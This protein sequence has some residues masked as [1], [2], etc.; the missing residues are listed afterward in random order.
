MS[1]LLEK[2]SILLTP[3][4]YDDGKILSV[5][6][7]EV[8]GEEK[9]VNGTFDENVNGWITNNANASFVW[10]INKTALFTSTSFAY[11]KVSPT[12]NLNAAVYKVSFDILSFE[13]TLSNVHIGLGNSGNTITTTG[14]YTYFY[15]S[16][17]GSTEF[18]IRPNSGGTGS[19]T[20]DNVSVKEDISGDFDFTRNSSATRVNSQGLIEDMQILSGN[21]VSNGDFSQEGSEE[22]TNG[23]FATDSDWGLQSGW[24]ISGNSLIGTNVNIYTKA[25]QTL[26]TKANTYYQV[27]IDVEEL[28]SSVY[29]F[30]QSTVG[31]QWKQ[32]TS[33][34]VHTFQI[35]SPIINSTIYIENADNSN[36]NIKINNVS[37]KEV[38]QD[39]TL[40]AGWGI[41][42]NKATSDASVSSYLNQTLYTI[43]NLY[44]LKFEV[45]EGTIELRSA[46]YS[47]GT[48]YYTTGIHEI[49]VIPTTTSTH[50][51]VYTGFGQS[52]ISNISAVEITD[53]TNLPRINYEGFSYQD[54]L[55]SELIVDG[56]FATDS[57][58]SKI[59]AT[60]SGGTGNLNGTGV[61]SMLYQ[62]IL[63]NGKTYKAIF[64]VSDYNGLGESRVIDS[65]GS[66]IYTI[67]SNGTFTFTFTHSNVDGNFL[68]R[69]RNG[70]IF[71]IDNVS[72]KEYLGQEPIPDSGCG[73]WLFEPQSTNLITYS[74]DFTQWNKSNAITVT[75]NATNSPSGDLNASLL[76]TTTTNR[77]IYLSV[78][79]TANST[80]SIYVKWKNGSGDID[81]S[82][83]GAS[84]YTSVSVTSE[85]TRVSITPSTSITQVVLRIPTAS[86]LYVWAAQVE[87]SS[88]AT[89]YIP[90]NGSTVTRLKDAAFG[91]GNSDLINSTEGV[92][93][94]EV[95][96]FANDILNTAISINQNGDF[97]NSVSIKFRSTENLIFG[98]IYSSGNISTLMQYTLPDDTQFNKIAISY[99]E[100]NFALWV[101]GIKVLTD[102]S[103]NAPIGLNNLSFN[104]GAENFFGKTKCLA[105]FKEALTDDELECLTTDETSYSSFTALAL[106]NN[107]T[108]I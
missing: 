47:K 91:S 4:A 42:T 81:L 69:A 97:T 18:Q 72:V 106:A 77:F 55:G 33:V 65:S 94:L 43:G 60:I 31:Q 24:S 59:N 7:E 92:L 28:G 85:W 98:L 71:S 78:S 107:Y 1:N 23:N 84:N 27:T 14:S 3:T 38:G 87:A 26:N 75:S 83:D 67:T 40:G 76:S 20:I 64:T 15:T 108:I 80:F 48:G 41:G 99:A 62:N 35:L 96:R 36:P 88:F 54:S 45:L 103:G 9:I 61:T 70:S 5:K 63:T 89:S 56:D 11:V 58:W 102:T 22:V 19:I 44:K 90:T 32:I 57:S 105:V 13:G 73:S 101:N 66:A 100:N 93:Y 16:T 82:V 68:F 34:G 37:V 6:P 74:E 8:L 30:F 79:S 46:Q 21:L 25:Y 86:E 29:V 50:F 53:D 12:L 49:E 51:Y 10:Q 52:S 2:A 17:G 95:S 104:L 39:W